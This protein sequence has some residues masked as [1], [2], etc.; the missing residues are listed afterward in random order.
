MANVGPEASWWDRAYGETRQ[1]RGWRIARMHDAVDEIQPR[2]AGG[3]RRVI[4]STTSQRPF[5]GRLYPD[6]FPN[7]GGVPGPGPYRVFLGQY[8][9]CSC[10]D[11]TKHRAFDPT[12]RCKHIWAA[13]FWLRN[14]GSRNTWFPPGQHVRLLGVPAHQAH[15]T[16]VQLRDWRVLVVFANGTRAFC[17]TNELQ[18]LDARGRVLVN[19]VTL[20]VSRRLEVT[21]LQG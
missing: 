18:R 8:P 17:N 13:A 21:I 15:G 6:Q 20:A 2:A 10:P 1:E 3:G 14:A 7:G 5:T 9:S 12:H 11:Y 4:Y 16:V 19:N